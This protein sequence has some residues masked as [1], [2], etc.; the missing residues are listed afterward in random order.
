MTAPYA[1]QPQAL[2]RPAC[3]PT[4]TR[5]VLA[6]NAGGDILQRYD[7]IWMRRSNMP[8]SKVT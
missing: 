3:T 2:P 6:V 1:R 4:A 7:G 8:A 5:A